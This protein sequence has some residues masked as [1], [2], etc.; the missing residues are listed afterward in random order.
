MATKNAQ[1]LLALKNSTELGKQKPLDRNKALDEILAVELGTPITPEQAEKF[2]TAV[3]KHLDFW[4]AVD[5]RV[6]PDGFSVWANW[7]PKVLGGKSSTDNHKTNDFLDTND[8]L[9]T[10]LQM[11]QA[12]AEERVKFGLS[13]ADENVLIDILKH[14]GQQCREYLAEKLR[15]EVKLNEIPGWDPSNENVLS[16]AALMNIKTEAANDLLLK[17]LDKPDLKESKIFKK[18]IDAHTSGVTANVQAAARELAKEAGIVDPT[19]LDAFAKA[20]TKDLTKA[21]T[22]KA[23]ARHKALEKA[24]HLA[25]FKQQLKDYE[26]KLTPDVL[27]GKGALLNRND[28]AFLTE[29]CSV[30]ELPAG[31]YNNGLIQAE[32]E[33]Q[34]LVKEMHKRLCAKY[35]EEK[36]KRVAAPINVVH[37]ADAIK[38]NRG[39][40]HLK[41]ALQQFIPGEGEIHDRAVLESSAKFKAALVKRYVKELTGTPNKALLEKL[42]KPETDIKEIRRELAAKIANGVTHEHLECLQDV[43]LKEIKEHARL[44]AFKLLVGEGNHSKLIAAFSSLPDKKQQELLNLK[45]ENLRFILNAQTKEQLKHYLGKDVNGKDDYLDGIVTENKNN[46]FFKQINNTE[47]AKILASFDKP[48]I[49]DMNDAKVKKINDFLFSKRGDDLA[50]HA[51][52][53][54]VIN[55]LFKKSGIAD[56]VANRKAF[57]N[58]FNLNDN[59]T[60]FTTPPGVSATNTVTDRIKRDHGYNQLLHTKLNAVRTTPPLQPG[61]EK[62]LDVLLRVEKTAQ[63]NPDHTNS[64][65]VRDKF[66]NSPTLEA[67]LAEPEVA[68]IRDKLKETLSSDEFN[69]IRKELKAN[70]AASNDHN[71]TAQLEKDIKEGQK[72][73]KQISEKTLALFERMQ[74]IRVIRGISAELGVNGAKAPEFVGLSQE[75][76]RGFDNNYKKLQKECLDSIAYLEQAQKELEA[77]KP[78]IPVRLTPPPPATAKQIKERDEVIKNARALEKDID[79]RLNIIQVRLDDYRKVYKV[80]TEEILPALEKASRSS[81]RVTYQAPDLTIGR[82]SRQNA[83]DMGH[84]YTLHDPNIIAEPKPRNTGVTTNTDPTSLFQATG[85]PDPGEVICFDTKKPATIVVQGSRG[86]MTTE[87]VDIEGRFTYDPSPQGGISGTM[88]GTDVTRAMP[89]RYE[90]V[91]SPRPTNDPDGKKK[92]QEITDEQVNFYMKMATQILSNVKLPLEK[93]IVLEGVRGKEDEVKYLYTSLLLVGEKMGLKP[94]DLKVIGDANF[95]PQAERKKTAGIDRG[96]SD[97]SFY[98]AIFKSRKDDGIVRDHIDKFNEQREQKKEQ[99]KTTAKVSSSLQSTMKEEF[100]VGREIEKEAKERQKQEGISPEVARAIANNG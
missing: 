33:I 48:P 66:Y 47:I 51:D 58:A 88:K 54:A 68:T 9:D 93:K 36:L 46:A 96:F 15:S 91:Q 27:V 17:L 43:D 72:A 7:A 75:K 35:V 13:S 60:A 79:Q 42:A 70:K 20:L 100:S 89:G 62:L 21:I 99:A 1:L 94:S 53:S 74:K 71:A 40:G 41:T 19:A 28:G 32:P 26:S 4:I 80:T 56:N 31:P 11:K 45:P 3:I 14:N 95:N 10:F 67:F 81:E 77:L 98:N 86:T 61:Y 83:L 25:E 34:N 90:V 18:L 44:E 49:T 2:K 85:K 52:Y 24:E 16:T 6:K 39:G 64:D 8:L 73:H 65:D 84:K 78:T 82:R 23:D 50:Q 76:L 38:E 29:L 30:H 69:A 97:T 87:N 63:F 55:K 5:A 92:A 37:M 59:G 22:D 12:A 57:Y